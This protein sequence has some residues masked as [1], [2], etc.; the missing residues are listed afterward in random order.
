MPPLDKLP[1]LK[2][3]CWQGHAASVVGLSN[4]EILQ[5]YERNWRYR[6]VVADL[7]EDEKILLLQL[8]TQYHSWIV[9]EI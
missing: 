2:S 6:G 9:N 1:F 5:L 3:L 7:S 8:A 4:D